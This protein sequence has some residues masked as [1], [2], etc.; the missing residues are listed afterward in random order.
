MGGTKYWGEGEADADLPVSSYDKA[1]DGDTSTFYDAYEST[2]DA[3]VGMKFNTPTRLTKVEIVPRN[4][5]LDAGRIFLDASDG[6]TDEK[7]D[8]LF[9]GTVYS[10][11]CSPFHNDEENSDNFVR[12]QT[13][14]PI[15]V[16]GYD[17]YTANDTA[18]FGERNPVSWALYGS[19]DGETWNVIDRQIDNDE[20]PEA[21]YACYYIDCMV[22]VLDENGN[23]VL[24]ENGDPVF[25]PHPEYSYFELRIDNV[26]GDI[27]Q[28]S[29]LR[30]IE[31]GNG[32][33]RMAGMTVQGSSDGICW[34]DLYVFPAEE[35]YYA[36][37]Y[38]MCADRGAIVN[39]YSFT[40]FRVVNKTQHLNVAEVKFYGV[41]DSTLPL[42]AETLP[43]G[44]HNLLDRGY[45]FGSDSW[46]G[47]HTYHKV[48]DGSIESD[49]YYD[50]T[51]DIKTHE[52][53][54]GIV[55]DNPAKLTGFN[56]YPRENWAERMP[57]LTVQGSVNGSDW[58]TPV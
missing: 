3:H 10:K 18:D 28:L 24:D 20:L 33:G 6:F 8:N 58:I 44:E 45:T 52:A 4:S 21:N 38:T 2:I 7:A 35:V 23:S 42:Y 16:V 51:D 1:F 47:G 19:A 12:W 48:F 32:V 46:D 36:Q 13:D 39:D 5:M 37:T 43:T 31:E 22:E 27:F 49:S 26:P 53:E 57:N 25:E 14:R 34:T 9:D 56:V 50:A 29:E 54:V 55:L 30:L 41:P 40:Q 15:A 17:I 11:W